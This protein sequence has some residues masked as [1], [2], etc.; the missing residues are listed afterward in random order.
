MEKEL[1]RYLQQEF[2]VANKRDNFPQLVQ[3]KAEAWI[4]QH[5]PSTKVTTSVNY[6]NEITIRLQ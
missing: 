5:Y 4:Q 6:F 1:R 2:Y 3:E